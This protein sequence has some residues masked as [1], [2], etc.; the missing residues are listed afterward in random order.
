[1][2]TLISF[3]S[4]TSG[5]H[6][7]PVAPA[8]LWPLMPSPWD[9]AL[10]LPWDLLLSIGS[11][12]SG[13][14][15]EEVVSWKIQNFFPWMT[16]YQVCLFVFFCP[17]N[18]RDTLALSCFLGS[19]APCNRELHKDKAKQDACR[20]FGGEADCLVDTVL[21]WEGALDSEAK[22][23]GLYVYLAEE[24]TKAHDRKRFAWRQ[25]ERPGLRLTFGVQHGPAVSLLD[26]QGLH[27][28]VFP[29]P[30]TCPRAAPS[31]ELTFPLRACTSRVF[32]KLYI[33]CDHKLGHF[34][35]VSPHLK[36]NLFSVCMNSVVYCWSFV[37]F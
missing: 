11:P 36:T 34:C 18:P 21:Q 12:C 14:R 32:V 22:V 33:K 6:G 35:P 24:E 28:H 25:W 10:S 4:S 23:L 26:H 7:V 13:K 37:L 30:S 15:K 8:P 9:T 20:H 1:M 5:S 31:G 19:G 29:L 27:T 2:L 16:R 17:H 3:N